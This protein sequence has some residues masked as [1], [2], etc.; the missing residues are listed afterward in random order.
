MDP[1]VVSVEDQKEILRQCV[2]DGINFAKRS[3]TTIVNK[4]SPGRLSQNMTLIFR[5]FC[6]LVDG[7]SL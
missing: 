6:D 4:Y 3:C 7:G 1:D 2:I 5:N